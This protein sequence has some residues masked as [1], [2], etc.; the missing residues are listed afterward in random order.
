MA[1]HPIIFRGHSLGSFE[2]PD[3]ADPERIRQAHEHWLR[4]KLKEALPPL[5]AVAPPAGAPDRT[6]PQA[7]TVACGVCGIVIQRSDLEHVAA[8]S[9]KYGVPQ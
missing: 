6:R 8:C 7:T 5:P 4:E 3:D 9:A 1:R 2:L